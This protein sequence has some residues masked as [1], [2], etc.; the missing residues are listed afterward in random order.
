MAPLAILSAELLFTPP[1]C[2]VSTAFPFPPDP[3]KTSPFTNNAF[4]RNADAAVW[5]NLEGSSS[6][7]K[8]NFDARYR[9]CSIQ[10]LGGQLDLLRSSLSR[11]GEREQQDQA[12]RRMR[13]SEAANAIGAACIASCMRGKIGFSPAC[14]DCFGSLSACTKTHCSTPCLAGSHLECRWCIASRCIP[15]RHNTGR[16]GDT[17][18]CF[19]QLAQHGF[20]ADHPNDLR[21]AGAYFKMAPHSPGTTVTTTTVTTVTTTETTV[22]T[23]PG[24]DGGGVGVGA[25][26]RDD[27]ELAAVVLRP[28]S[29]IRTPTLQCLHHPRAPN[30]TTTAAPAPAPA[31]A[32][33]LRLRH[34]RKWRD[35][36]DRDHAG[37]CRD[38][39]RPYCGLQASISPSAWLHKPLSCRSKTTAAAPTSSSTTTASA[40]TAANAAKVAKADSRLVR[41]LHAL[42]RLVEQQ[43]G[44]RPHE[45]HE[46]SRLAPEREDAPDSRSDPGLGR[47]LDLRPS[48]DRTSVAVLANLLCPAT[49]GALSCPLSQ[50]QHNDRRDTARRNIGV[51]H[52]REPVDEKEGG[53]DEA[54]ATGA[55]GRK[56]QPHHQARRLRG[57]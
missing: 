15:G 24:R 57:G 33:G 19:A 38:L 5:R 9:E 36:R 17:G 51:E 7:A 12:A 48:R 45:Q 35:W 21:T 52:T 41:R 4:I 27:D 13:A 3:Y 10:C 22:Q 56:Q 50:Y 39:V 53:E 32:S 37:F 16:H 34:R 8:Q 20:G 11:I 44:A 25:P 6:S 42:A 14:S 26:C 28:L 40:T 55:G 1:V 30:C 43:E 18:S 31:P 2:T 46:Q 54:E 23:T 29:R 47:G 49:C